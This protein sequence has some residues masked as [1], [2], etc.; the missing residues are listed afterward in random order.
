VRVPERRKAV[1]DLVAGLTVG[2]VQI[3]NGMATAI[4]WGVKPTS[5]LNAQIVGTPAGAIFGGSQFM[6]VVTTAAIGLSVGSALANTP[7]DQPMPALFVPTFLV[8]LIEIVMGLLR[9]AGSA[10]SSRTASWSASS[11]ASAC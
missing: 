8:G 10:A 1:A 3:P 5:G 7:T 6:A 2:V 9:T 11:P 4:L